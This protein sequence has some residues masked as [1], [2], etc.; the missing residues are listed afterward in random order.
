MHS[1]RPTAVREVLTG[2]R[3]IAVVGAS[4]DPR[5]PSHGVV[6]RLVAAGYDV[7]PVNPNA[8]DVLGLIAVPSL[9]AVE[10]PIDIVD[11]FRAAEHA[12]AI[13]RAAVEAGAAALW[14]QQGVRSDEARAIAT[15]AGLEYVE[16]ACLAVE[17]ERSGATPRSA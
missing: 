12:P 5:R 3:R 15:A 13:A 16:D 9:A 1:D 2:A 17:V 7:T 6:R 4:P 8:T 10:G 11:V 14:L